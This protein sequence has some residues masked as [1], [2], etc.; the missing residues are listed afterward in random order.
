MA[1]VDPSLSARHAKRPS[2]AFFVPDGWTMAAGSPR[3]LPLAQNAPAAAAP[4]TPGL[5]GNRF[6]LR[7]PGKG[8]HRGRMIEFG[9]LTHV[10]LR[11][12]LN[13]DT[14]YGDSELGLWLVADG[15]G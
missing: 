2:R 9:H 7:F 4:A 13:E 5:S 1:R 10:G 12:E 8:P 6:H 3:S 15:M 14:Y 11:R